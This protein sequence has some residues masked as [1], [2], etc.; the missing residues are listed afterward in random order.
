MVSD[1]DRQRCEGMS[2]APV[3]TGKGQQ[4]L[5][6]RRPQ[7]RRQR[8]RCRLLRDTSVGRA[9][10]CEE[11]M[12]NTITALPMRT[13]DGDEETDVDGSS[14]QGMSHT[15]AAAAVTAA[16][17]T[18][19]C[20]TSITANAQHNQALPSCFDRGRGGQRVPQTCTQ[21]CLQTTRSTCARCCGGCGRQSAAASR[22]LSV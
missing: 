1:H 17:R 18:T 4:L 2:S 6:R 5:H 11:R 14:S 16:T 21:T 12:N 22:R 9:S 19:Q 13:K 8:L 3:W 15:P 7:G 20:S 10:S